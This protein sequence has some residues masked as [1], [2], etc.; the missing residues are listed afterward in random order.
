MSVEIKMRLKKMEKNI[1][2][3]KKDFESIF[4]D[5]LEDE[6]FPIILNPFNENAYIFLKDLEEMFYKYDE[7]KKLFFYLEGPLGFLQLGTAR[8]KKD[9]LRSSAIYL[10]NMLMPSEYPL[11]VLIKKE[12]KTKKRINYLLEKY[13]IKTNTNYM[14]GPNK[15]YLKKDKINKRNPLD[16]RLRHECFK[17]DGYKCK[18]C[19][20]T[21]E[22]KMLHCDHIISVSQNGSDELDN[23]QT[24]CNDCNLAKS[25][26]CWIGGV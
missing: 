11:F 7:N 4:I 10:V 23:L 22:E 1:L 13:K 6:F 2:I 25:N 26:K 12:E 5:C 18:E 15:N 8:A 9:G 16:S 24:L 19:G 17:R 21:K 20:A 14:T 3:S